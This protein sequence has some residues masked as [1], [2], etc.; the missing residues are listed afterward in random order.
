[1]S[2][3]LFGNDV[4]RNSALAEEELSILNLMALPR[5]GLAMMESKLH[6]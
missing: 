1:M 3:Q 2:S 5:R 6:F 4:K